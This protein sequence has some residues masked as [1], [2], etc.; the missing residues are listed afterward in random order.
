MNKPV[1][2][3]ALET[4]PSKKSVD[5]LLRGFTSGIS[6]RALEPRIAFDGAAVATAAA[7]ADAHN[8]QAQNHASDAGAKPAVKQADG[9]P[10]AHQAVRDDTGSALDSHEANASPADASAKLADAIAAIEAPQKDAPVTI[11]FIDESVENINQIVSKIDPSWEIVVVDDN[12][13]GLS[14]MASYLSGRT[15]VGSIHVVSHGESGTLYLGSDALTSENLADYQA[16]LSN[17]G[18]ALN[19]NGDILLYGCDIAAGSGGMDFVRAFSEYTGADIAAS[20]NRTGGDESGGDWVLEA[21]SGAIEAKTLENPLYAGILAKTNTGAWTAN[22]ATAANDWLNTTDG[23]TTTVTF[24]NGGSGTWTGTAGD[25]LNTVAGGLNATTFDNGAVG[26]ASVA[27]TFSTTNTTDVGTITITF[28]TAVTN[29][30][31]HI[32]RL[33]GV[34]GTAN[35][36]LLT[37]TSGGTLTR[38][39]GVGHFVVDSGA[40][41]ITRQVGVTTNGSESSTNSAN[42]TAAGSIRVNGTY[43]TITFSVRMNSAAAAGIGDSMELAFAIDAPPTALNDTFATTKAVASTI[44]VRANDTDPRGDAL[45]VTQ[46]NG[47]AIT[48]GGGGVNVTGGVV[49]LNASGNLIYTPNGTYTGTST[50]TYTIS[51]ANGGTSTA[52]VTGTITNIAPIIDLNS[53]GS[54]GDTNRG[55]SATFNTGSPTPIAVA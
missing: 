11:V 1:R 3:A 37:L 52:T 27:S 38:L 29:P 26:A 51:D 18:A 5:E 7:T 35:S 22:G 34:S 6:Y 12:S 4:S 45:T 44:N 24:T 53:T 47:T 9:V 13:S 31:I 8:D 36:A 16:Q 33:G 23:I 14:Q 20:V 32:D 19:D 55:Y 42:G 43:T 49:T 17:I 25:T 2:P 54:T 21:T 40:G 46:V 50:F 10:V 28:S 39:S 15:D 41:T 48:A 30:V